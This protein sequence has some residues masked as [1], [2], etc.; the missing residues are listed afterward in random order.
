M[1][2]ALI[3]NDVAVKTVGVIKEYQMGGT[4]LRALKGIDVE[5]KR[6]EYISIMG[7]SGSGKSTLFNM[8]GALDRPSGGT[9]Y[10]DDV[11]L[12][13]LSPSEIAWLRCWKIGY[14]F[15]TFNL[16]PVMTALENVTLPMIFAGLSASERK[17][18]GM[19]L[20]A[21]VGLDQRADHKPNEL[22]G[23]Q[24][25]RVAIARSLANGPSIILADEPTGNLDLRTGRDII[26]I[27]RG[28]NKD[29]N[30]TIISATH[31]LKMLDA[32]DRVIYIRDGLVEQIKNRADLQLEIGTIEGEQE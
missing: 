11:N 23:G 16:I 3:K 22:S 15:Q 7:P 18:K 17:E 14:I 8:I 10:I 2:E 4:I 19:A 21:K 13:E 1:A 32:S 28:M 9:V 27:L 25:Q 12:L 6:G 29:E 26:N 5:I 20:L 31:D 30:V 24:Q